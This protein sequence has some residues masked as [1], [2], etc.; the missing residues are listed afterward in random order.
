MLSTLIAPY[1][2]QYLDSGKIGARSVGVSDPAQPAR[3]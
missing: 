2:I 3:V 1:V